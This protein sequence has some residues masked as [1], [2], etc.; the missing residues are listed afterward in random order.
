MRY[1]PYLVAF[2]VLCFA[3]GHAKA[4]AS[5]PL[6][7]NTLL[8]W[9]KI[10]DDDLYQLLHAVDQRGCFFAVKRDKDG[11][12]LFCHYNH[13]LV[14]TPHLRMLEITNPA[15]NQRIMTPSSTKP[16]PKPVE[17]VYSSSKKI[18]QV[19]VEKV[20]PVLYAKGRMVTLTEHQ[21]PAIHIVYKDTNDK[22]KVDI[23]F[24]EVIEFPADASN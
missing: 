7:P 13:K 23:L 2:A 11:D 6:S 24:D 12:I 3:H 8:N 14:D 21:L 18:G 9:L 1:I 20:V 4:D 10:I 5:A 19:K 16:S 17:I 15:N 22:G